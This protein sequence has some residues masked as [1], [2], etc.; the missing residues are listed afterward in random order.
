VGAPVSLLGDTAAWLADSAH[1]SGT[2]GVP[3]RLAEHLAVSGSAVALG[4]LIAL[5]VAFLLGHTGRGGSLA[6]NLSNASRA[7]PTFALLV[8]LAATPVGFGNRAT[9]VA[10]TV[11]A[12]PP[13]LT[14][15][16]VGVR[17]VDP[18][19]REAA[20][21]MGMTGLQLLRKVELPLALPLVAAAMISITAQPPPLAA[22]CL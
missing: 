6:V 22:P 10:L 7:V 9:V 20:R 14:N 12:V 16:Y 5:P 2:D 13:I 8:L 15:A 19:V 1:W 3:H 18:E 4:C 21:G 17:D 11:F